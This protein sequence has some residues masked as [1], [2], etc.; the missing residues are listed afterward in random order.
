M[1]MNKNRGKKPFP[2][3]CSKCR[4]KAVYD[5]VTDYALDLEFDK[6]TYHVKIPKLKTP[7][8]RKCGTVL[9]D[10]EADEQI[11]AVFMRLAKLLTPNK[12]RTYRERLGLS[13]GELADAIGVD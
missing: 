12:I 6:G 4:E 13:Q 10:S 3:T 2:W 1:H 11:T 8:C 9:I 7:R 5:G